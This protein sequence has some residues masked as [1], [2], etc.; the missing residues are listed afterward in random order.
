MQAINAGPP[1]YFSGSSTTGAQSFKPLLTPT[2]PLV[3]AAAQSS[4]RCK[5]KLV[6]NRGIVD[7]TQED[8]E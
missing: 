4:Q 6:F 1:D 7:L 2:Q 8:V 3:E 5:R